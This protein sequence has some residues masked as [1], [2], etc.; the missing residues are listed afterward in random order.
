M[1]P[2]YVDLEEHHVQSSSCADSSG[3]DS[4]GKCYWSVSHLYNSTFHTMLKSNQ[5]VQYGTLDLTFAYL[6]AIRQNEL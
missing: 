4:Y 6:N 2:E 5:V 3:E 1:Y